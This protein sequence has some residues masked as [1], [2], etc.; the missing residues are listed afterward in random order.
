MRI[1]RDDEATVDDM[2]RF[3]AGLGYKGTV[4]DMMFQYLGDR[5]YFGAL[6]D[7]LLSSNFFPT[8][9][10]VL[11]TV[12][13]TDFDFDVEPATITLES[14]EAGTVFWDFNSTENTAL[15][16]GSGDYTSGSEAVI[17]GANAFT[18]ALGAHAGSSGYLH[19]RLRNASLVDSSPATVSAMFTVPAGATVPVA[20]GAPTMASTGS[21]T[22]NLTMP[23][24]PS[25]GGSAIT[26]R[27]YRYSD[28]AEASWSTPATIG[29]GA[30]VGLT[31][32]PA[33]TLI[34]GQ[35]RAVNA[36]GNSAWS[37]S[38][39]ATTGAAG[40]SLNEVNANNAYYTRT[41]TSQYS[42]DT[43]MGFQGYIYFKNSFANSDRVFDGMGATIST[44]SSGA[45]RL[46]IRDDVSGEFY[47]EDT[48]STLS[49]NTWYHF[50]LGI[51]LGSG[52]NGTLTFEIDGVSAGLAALG[53]NSGTLDGGTRASFLAQAGGTNN[54][55][56]N[57]ANLIADMGSIPSS[58]YNS[59]TPLDP[60]T[61][62]TLGSLDVAL[63][64]DA[65]DMNSETNSGTATMDDRSD[66]ATDV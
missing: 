21:T 49:L 32:L 38:G 16:I 22:M 35:V 61:A 28:D 12:T 51:D 64:G 57:F 62:L 1:L 39:T 63:V 17:S 15:V 7:R 48:A 26:S 41:A 9:S 59:G 30:T 37:V 55:D 27:E 36:I 25:D 2:R 54:L 23:A 50:Y 40:Y 19:F 3:L 20:P 13:I 44:R 11:P 47:Q 42:D 5:G 52:G 53:S 45:I 24:D 6:S 58:L 56:C 31:G 18:I 60:S 34:S 66:A 43:S 14:S 33:S 46:E 8:D 4:N 65:A 29:A 10:A